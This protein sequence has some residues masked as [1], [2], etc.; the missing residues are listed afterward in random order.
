MSRPLRSGLGRVCAFVTAVVLLACGGAEV[1]EPAPP[2][3][4]RAKLERDLASLDTKQPLRLRYNPGSCDCPPYEA[5]IAGVWVRADWSNAGQTDF[6]ALV[7]ALHKTAPE[8]WPLIMKLEARIDGEALRTAQGLYSV[9]FEA[10]K[11]VKPPAFPA[12]ITWPPAKTDA[13]AEQAEQGSGED[14]EKGV[15]SEAERSR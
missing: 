11:L 8:H 7:E 10:A 1:A 3:P 12:S 9:R 4:V 13:A 14:G 2:N 15:D 6:V 5:E